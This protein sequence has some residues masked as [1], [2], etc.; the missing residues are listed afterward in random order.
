MPDSTPDH[1]TWRHHLLVTIIALMFTVLVVR[2]AQIQIIDHEQYSE[3]AAFTHYGATSVPAPRGAIIDSTGY[4]L[5]IS[6]PSWDIYL[7]SHLWRDRKRASSAAAVLASKLG[8]DENH[9]LAVGT[10]QRQGDVLLLRNL[11]YEHGLSLKADDLWGVRLISSAIR[12]YPEG[13][14]AGPLIGYVGLGGE[15]LWGIESDYDQV[16]AGR[17]V[18]S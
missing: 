10:G 3:Q 12:R 8:F 17:P 13:G 9:I 11:D 6:V 1:F 2:L 15:G 18:G 7:D 4:P 16:L 5:A 14:L